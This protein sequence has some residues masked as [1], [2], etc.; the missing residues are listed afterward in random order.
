M[1]QIVENAAKEACFFAV[2]S[3]LKAS[4]HLATNNLEESQRKILHDSVHEIRDHVP[5]ASYSIPKVIGHF[6]ESVEISQKYSLGNCGELAYSALHY[7]SCRYPELRAE[8]YTIISG[9]HVF[10]VIDRK[11]GSNERDPAT[12]GADAFICDPLVGKYYPAADYK[13]ELKAFERE[14]H[15]INKLYEIKP[16]HRFLSVINSGEIREQVVRKSDD[17]FKNLDSA[18]V[19]LK[20]DLFVIVKTLQS[21][22]EENT[23]KI[24]VVSNLIKRLEKLGDLKNPEKLY[25]IYTSMTQKNISKISYQT[26]GELERALKIDQEETKILNNHHFFESQP[27]IN[28][29]VQWFLNLIHYFPES[30]SNVDRALDKFQKNLDSFI[31]TNLKNKG[32][33]L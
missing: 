12:W 9:D 19:D 28:S 17:L 16:F 1:T 20:K 5:L 32:N 25:N 27:I 21:K 7:L 23:D 29:W 8:A 18:L 13:T 33:S 3:I 24:L 30:K 4:T 11:E 26:V 31:E 6:F 15:Y 14:A 10:V 22:N 2:Q